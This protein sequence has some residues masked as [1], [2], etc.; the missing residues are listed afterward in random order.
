MSQDWADLGYLVAAV[1]FILALKGLSSPEDRPQRQPDR[2]GR[3]AARRRRRVRRRAISTT[4]VPILVAIAVGTVIGAVVAR[5]VG[6][7]RD[8]A[9]GGAVQRGRRRRRGDRRAARAVATPDCAVARLAAALFTV[10]IG[11]VSFAGSAV[12]FAKLQELMTDAAGHAPRRAGPVRRPRRWPTSLACWWAYE[13]QLDGAAALPAAARRT[14]LAR[15]RRAVRAAGRRRGRADRD[16]AA[17]RVHRPHGRR[18]RL[19]ARQHAA[20][21]RRHA[22]RRV[23]HDPHPDDGRGHGPLGR[24]HPVRGVPGRVDG[25]LAGGERPAGAVGARRGRRDP[26]RLRAQGRHRARATGWRSRRRST[27][28]TSWSSCWRRAASTSRTASTRSPAGCPGT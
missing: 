12:T 11:S 2:R 20:D 25:R 1:C 15:R 18:E 3:R 9:A 23:R 5:R 14:D 6:D 10:V 17:Q 22:R 13:A 7:D 4:L 26:A 28:S 24:E 8:A 19:R 27:R 21:R 16:L